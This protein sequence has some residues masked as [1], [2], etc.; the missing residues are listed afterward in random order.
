MNKCIFC[1]II[2]DNKKKNNI[3]YENKKLIIFPDIKPKAN[4]HL[5]IVSKKHIESLQKINYIDKDLL[6]HMLLIIPYISKLYKLY[7]GFKIIINTGEKG[8]QEINHLH[9]HFLRNKKTER[10]L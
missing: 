9:F 6:G 8:G 4:I 7:D 10:G 5:L 1:E 3:I 2:K